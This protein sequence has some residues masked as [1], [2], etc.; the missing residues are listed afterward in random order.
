MDAIKP[1]ADQHGISVIE[2]AAHAL[3]AIYR[4]RPI[5]SISRFTTFSF[6]AIKHLTTGD[7]GA[8]CC[9]S[10]A[11]EVRAKAGRWFGID[12]AAS[13]PNILGERDYDLGRLGFKYHMNN[14]AAA[15]GLGNLQNFYQRLAQ[16]RQIAERY[17]EGLQNVG[18]LLL[19]EYAPD[20][21]SS[22]WFF[23]IRVDG[24]DDFASAMHGRKVAC[25]VVHRRIDRNSMYV[26]FQRELPGQDEFD[27]LQINLPVHTGLSDEDIENVVAAVRA[28]W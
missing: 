10:R 23:P 4:D 12:R 6:Q 27:R 19:P 22:W 15:I 11:D 9:L 21:L 16:H 2:D 13:T 1:V 18:G 3:G 5:G 20:R 25:S 17:L 7:G 8:L 26:P 14:V 24:R 28:G